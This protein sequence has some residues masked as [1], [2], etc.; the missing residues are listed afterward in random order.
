VRLPKGQ[1]RLPKGQVRLP[2]GFLRLS[3][4]QVRLPKGFLRLPK[5]LVR[6]LTTRN[7]KFEMIGLLYQP[8][9]A[10]I[11]TNFGRR[12]SHDSRALCK[13]G[14]VAASWKIGC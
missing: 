10:A 14:R 2:K 1:V 8:F 4:G 3:K 13:P 6:L 7:V 11:R 12:Q 9:Q 5:G